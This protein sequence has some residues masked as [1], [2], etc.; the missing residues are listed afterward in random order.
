MIQIT[1]RSRP[2]VLLECLVLLCGF[3]KAGSIDPKHI[4][5]Q[6]FTKQSGTWF[7]GVTVAIFASFMSTFGINLQKYSHMQNVRLPEVLQKPYYQQFLWCCGMCLLAASSIC[8]FVAL[9][10]VA[11][12]LIAPLGSF[13]LTAN[14]LV[15]PCFLKESITRH[16]LIATLVTTVGCFLA[17]ASA[18]HSETNYTFN[19][20]VE[21]FLTIPYL[22]FFFSSVS[23]MYGANKFIEAIEHD[24]AWEN[25]K[26]KY[27][28][29][30]WPVIGGT[31]G[32]FSVTFAKAFVEMI[33]S[34]IS[35]EN[36]F[37][38][39][40]PYI[41]TI[42]L[43]FFSMVQ[44]HYLNKGLEHYKALQVIPVYQT[45]WILGCAAGGVV[46]FQEFNGFGLKD[47]LLFGLGM[48]VT[49]FGVVLLSQRG[50]EEG[51]IEYD[52]LA[53]EDEHDLWLQSRK[54]L[55]HKHARK[56]QPILLSDNSLLDSDEDVEFI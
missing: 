16:D 26:H 52:P 20:L 23:F 48:C 49:I 21:F 8:D 37:L 54:A 46:Y 38:K 31:A 34:T 29:F 55:K 22:I 7:L 19:E 30:L 35:G 15:A 2:A 56:T 17:V 1:R 36:E 33:K 12:S 6:V 9:A 44:V 28:S 14:I 27:M 47:G 32:S 3:Q 11:Q 41:V 42:F 50:G 25:D 10:F 13:S 4:V 5:A 51:E 18:N 45:C 40:G 24:P 39:P 53:N 43:I